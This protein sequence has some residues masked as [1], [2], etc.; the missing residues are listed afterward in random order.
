MPEIPEVALSRSH[1][2]VLIASAGCGKTEVIA[3]AVCLHDGHR[4]LVLT[5][6]HA[7]V[8]ALRDRFRRLN[9]PSRHF[10]IDTIAGWALSYAHSYPA[11]SGLAVTEPTEDDEW[12]QVYEAA[13]QLL[14]QPAI[15]RVVKVSYDGVYVDEYQDCTLPQHNL[16]MR[17]ANILPCRILGDPLQGIFDFNEPVVDWPN[18]VLPY[19]EQLPELTTPW[20]WQNV[21]PVLGGWLVGVRSALLTGQPIDLTGGPLT[22]LPLSLQNQRKACFTCAGQ[23]G[24]VVAVH[25]T[26]QQAHHIA[27][28]LRGTFTSMDEVYCKELFTWADRLDH[29]AGPQLA[30]NLID[31][32]SKCMTKVSSELGLIKT[33]L[34]NH[35]TNWERLRKHVR[36]ARL[37]RQVAESGDLT[38]MLLA[39]DEIERLEGRV[40]HRRELWREM[41]K[42]IHER[43]HGKHLS[44]LQTAWHVRSKTSIVGRRLERRTVSRTLLIKGLEFD[45]AIVLD[46]DTLNAK[47]LY[48]ALTRG[49]RSL[50]VLS[51]HPTVRKS[52]PF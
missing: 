45:R 11:L 30:I 49:A 3:R 20:R 50:T 40:L 2:A 18:D 26:P 43:Q 35:T 29:S 33:K 31:F 32:A 52:P 16:V 38:T 19:F 41:A 37:L 51:T 5:H 8:R 9:V 46:A 34:R 7:G 21:N 27:R 4:Q 36:V 23:D 42:S 24:S 25:K 6:T 10:H 15:R 44:I 48:V 47:E 1:R 22:W 17:L 13:T 14:G 39:M 28:F 12:R